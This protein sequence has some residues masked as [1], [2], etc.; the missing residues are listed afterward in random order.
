MSGICLEYV[1]RVIWSYVWYMPEIYFPSHLIICGI[2]Q[3][4]VWDILSESFGHMSGIY[5]T[6]SFACERPCSSNA[7]GRRLLGL[8]HGDCECCHGCLMFSSKRGRHVK[9]WPCQDWS[10]SRTSMAPY[11]CQ[12]RMS[13]RRLATWSVLGGE[14]A[15][16]LPLETERMSGSAQTR[17]GR[18][19][20]E[21]RR[22][23]LERA[24]CNVWK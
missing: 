7:I 6:Y 1:F 23:L 22:R 13:R 24:Q 14:L 8:R 21:P 12:Q 3:V 20:S 2:C 16:V 9:H 5:L 10:M 18:Q 15:I 19:P 4:Y 11:S 17:R